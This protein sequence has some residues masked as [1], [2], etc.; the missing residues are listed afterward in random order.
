LKK[1]KSSPF[2]FPEQDLLMTFKVLRLQKVRSLALETIDQ[3]NEARSSGALSGPKK[4]ALPAAAAGRFS[5]LFN[6]LNADFE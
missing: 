5:R 3:A 2:S 1:R 6:G 4:F